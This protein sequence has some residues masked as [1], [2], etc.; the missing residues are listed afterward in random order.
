M[1]IARG[2]TFVRRGLAA[3]RRIGWQH[4]EWWAIAAAVCAWVVLIG[5]NLQALGAGGED[6]HLHGGARQEHAFLA[7]AIHWQLMVVAMTLPLAVP[8]LRV[9][10]FRSLWNRRHRTMGGFVTGYLAVWLLPGLA[11]GGLLAWVPQLSHEW[12][13]FAA[14]SAFLLAAAW[15]WTPIK[16]RALIACHATAPLAPRGWR[17]DRDAILF[18]WMSGRSCLGSCG[19]SMV[20]CTLAGHPLVALVACAWLAVVERYSWRPNTKLIGLATAGLAL[21]VGLF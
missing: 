1:N 8:S 14:A 21:I 13:T 4:P 6:H 9:A 10:A 16:R 18:G 7:S 17:A 19:V 20:A 5:M 2:T 11:L 15:Q 3:L 12:K